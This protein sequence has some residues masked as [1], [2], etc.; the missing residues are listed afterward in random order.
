VLESE[1]QKLT[2]NRQSLQTI[3]DF[4]R[5]VEPRRR[6]R[7]C[8]GASGGGVTEASFALVS[9]T[10]LAERCEAASSSSEAALIAAEVFAF[11]GVFE[12]FRSRRSRCLWSP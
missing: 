11:R 10:D 12:T 9:R 6:R 5:R 3:L 4:E 8:G 7:F 1:E 2:A